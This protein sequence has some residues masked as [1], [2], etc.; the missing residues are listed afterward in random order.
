[1]LLLNSGDPHV[2]EVAD[3]GRLI[4]KGEGEYLVTQG[5]LEGLKGMRVR[6]KKQDRIATKVG[7]WIFVSG[8]LPDSFIEAYTA[9]TGESLFEPADK[10]FTKK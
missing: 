4:L 3:E 5:R 10:P 7:N 6:Y 2:Q 1:M 9:Q 8:Y